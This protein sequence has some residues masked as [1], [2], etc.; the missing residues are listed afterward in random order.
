LTYLDFPTKYVW[1]ASDKV[2]KK[3]QIGFAIGRIYNALPTSGE[4]YYLQILLNIIKEC[5][6]FEDIRTVNRIVYP[7]FKD[8]CQILGYLDDDNEWI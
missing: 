5:M 2:W 8:V 3:R 6:P 1:M 7:T 4:R